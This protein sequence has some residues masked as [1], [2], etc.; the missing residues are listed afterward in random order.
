MRFG[1]VEIKTIAALILRRFRL[2][3]E[4]GWKLEIRQTPT[5]GPRGGMPVVVRAAS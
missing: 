1:Q 5:L 4:P 2:E 3:V